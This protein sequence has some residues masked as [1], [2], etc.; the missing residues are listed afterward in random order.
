LLLTFSISGLA[1]DTSG[2][3]EAPKLPAK[4]ASTPMRPLATTAKPGMETARPLW[5]ELTPAQQLALTPL[6]A[7][8]NT[9][10]EPHK[11]K[12]LAVSKNYSQ[13]PGTEQ[14]KLQSRMSEWATL[15]A[16][17]RAQARINFAQTKTISPIEKQAKW[18]AYQALS[19]EEKSKLA[20]KAAVP[21][22]GAAPA[23]KPSASQQ[24]T[25]VPTSHQSVRPGQKISTVEN[26]IDQK[27]LLPRH[28]KAPAASSPQ[29]SASLP[30]T[31]QAD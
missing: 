4:T 14:V 8:W 10:S 5:S 27:T 12:W 1:A 19:P 3:L 2:P 24:L 30:G 28:E 16:Q 20:V 21:P 25:V 26:R 11:R 6:F 9:L 23:V 17:Q 31:V 7:T 13:L 15:S 29:S 22:K 18:Q